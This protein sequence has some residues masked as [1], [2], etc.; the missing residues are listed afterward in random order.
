MSVCKMAINLL[1]SHISMNPIMHSPT[2]SSPQTL[3]SGES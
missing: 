3:G 2:L 1:V